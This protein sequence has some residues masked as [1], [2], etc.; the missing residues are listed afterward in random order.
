MLAIC[1][2]DM[3]AYLA[4]QSQMHMNEF[5]TV[6]KLLE[7]SY[8]GKYSEESLGSLDHNGQC[9]EQ[10]LFCKLEKLISLMGLD[11]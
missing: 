9:V 8:V 10:K 6:S 2:Q 3:S 1:D 7:M 11:I 5:N 4:E